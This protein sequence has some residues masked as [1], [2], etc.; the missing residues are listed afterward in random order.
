MALP[1]VG[2]G[3]FE[4]VLTLVSVNLPNAT[5]INGSAFW[6][7]SNLESVNI[8]H[9]TFIGGNAF[10]DCTSLK[11]IVMPAVADIGYNAFSGD[12]ALVEYTL[13]MYWPESYDSLE[14]AFAGT[15]A[16]PVYYVPK[17]SQFLEWGAFPGHEA[18]MIVEQG[19]DADLL[20]VI[21]SNDAIKTGDAFDVN[22]GFNTARESNAATLTFSFAAGLFE[23]T[24]FT[25]AEGVTCI[26]EAVDGGTV[27]VIV[28]LLGSYD[29]A[30]LGSAGFT[31]KG[32]GEEA[33]IHVVVDYILRDN[34]EKSLAHA[35]G[36]VSI[37]AQ[38]VVM[39]TEPW[40]N[41]KPGTTVAGKTEVNLLDLSNVIDWF[42]LDATATDWAGLIR[43]F[44]FNENGKIDI[45]DIVYV[46]QQIAA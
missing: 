9:V 40:D 39:P 21:V 35:I 34:D 27:K 16:T 11:S 22:V 42:G 28:A 25:P 41:W 13:G 20:N 1:S 19:E 45:A 5:T 12:A 46:A 30:D 4:G 23:Y 29:M 31:Y 24:C 18:T 43:F 17:N 37:S 15:Y 32:A 36:G 7:C 2:W 3:A 8:P 38:G 10:R 44:D 33:D 26:D 14:S 6:G